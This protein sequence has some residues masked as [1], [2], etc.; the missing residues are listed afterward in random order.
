MI[1]KREITVAGQTMKNSK[2]KKSSS[3]IRIEII[4]KEASRCMDIRVEKTCLKMM[5]KIRE[6]TAMRGEKET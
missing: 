5:K 1:A 3:E 2:E 6:K 4:K